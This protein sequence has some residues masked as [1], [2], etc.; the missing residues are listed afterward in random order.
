MAIKKYNL[1]PGTLTLGAGA[2]AVEG[3]L[4]NCRV[5]AAEQVTTTEAI[6]VLSG[7]ELAGS[8]RVTF[9]WTLAGTLLQDLEA[10][11]VIDWSWANKGTE[12]PF[13]FV[14]NTVEGRQVSGICKPVPITIGGDVTGTAANPGDPAQS[15]FTW[16]CLNGDDEPVFGDVP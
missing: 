13:T 4:R 1:G 8:D 5:E 7:E 10:A 9:T 15:D 2:L 16:R 12:Q 11:G 6:P 3:Q 14:P